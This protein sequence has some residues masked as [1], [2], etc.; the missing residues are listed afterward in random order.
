MW[1][2]ES[3]ATKIWQVLLIFMLLYTATILPYKLALIDDD[4]IE[5][6]TIDTV[7][8]FLFI[9]DIYVNFNTPIEFKVDN[10]NFNR[11]AIA[12][13]Y[14]NSWFL[15]DCIGSIPMNLI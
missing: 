7:F 5:L 9:F 13:N 6:F 15:I 3:T 11:R 1:V 12:M 4:N 2:P 10:Y 8:D 14:I